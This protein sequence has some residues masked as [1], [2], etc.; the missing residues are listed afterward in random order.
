MN[1]SSLIELENS[2]LKKLE[3]Y[4]LD[5]QSVAKFKSKIK[6]VNAEESDKLGQELF[7]RKNHLL[8]RKMN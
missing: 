2:R 1:N 5:R 8:V 3:E 7:E 6:K 4:K